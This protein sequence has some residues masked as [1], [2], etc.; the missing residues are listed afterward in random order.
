[1]PGRLPG[2]SCGRRAATRPGR[3]ARARG[4]LVAPDAL[5]SRRTH[6]CRARPGYTASVDA[7]R[8]RGLLL[9]MPHVAET[10]QWGANLVFWAGEKALGGKMFALI[11]LDDGGLPI[12]FAC[13]A[14]HAAELCEGEGLCPAPYFARLHWVAAE[15]WS[16]L[17]A[18]AWETEL[19]SAHA[20]VFN[21][22]PQ[23]TRDR[24]HLPA[25]ERA[26]LI[27]E[28]NEAS[29]KKLSKQQTGSRKQRTTRA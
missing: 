25:K 11:N 17:S 13:T 29:K 9:K 18:R 21:K 12:S 8:A 16:A 5:L 7:E 3:T 19:Q 14:E 2:Q 28:R 20:I 10:L 6:S 1:M 26:T 27:A 15:R 4:T 24:L 23:R 22:L